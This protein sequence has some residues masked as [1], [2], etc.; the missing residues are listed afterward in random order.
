MERPEDNTLGEGGE[1][2]GMESGQM[3]T[4]ANL[5]A[6]LGGEVRYSGDGLPGGY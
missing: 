5:L 4:Y 3:P 1:D 6:A 2:N